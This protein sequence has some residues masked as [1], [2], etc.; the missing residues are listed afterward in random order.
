VR[1]VCEVCELNMSDRRH[2]L[3]RVVGWVSMWQLK[4]AR[5]S[6]RIMVRDCHEV[7][8]MIIGGFARLLLP[9]NLGSEGQIR[10]ICTRTATLPASVSM[11]AR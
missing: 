2:R 1:C 11:Y 6:A 7:T 4:P 3:E 5:A 10:D 8:R 9:S